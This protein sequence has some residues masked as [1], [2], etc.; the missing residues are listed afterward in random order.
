MAWVP[1]W[2]RRRLGVG[3]LS[4]RAS[5]QL[6]QPRDEFGPGVECAGGGIK[7]GLAITEAA[8]DGGDDGGDLGARELRAE[9]PGGDDGAVPV[10]AGGVGGAGRMPDTPGR[11][12]D[13]STGLP[14]LARASTLPNGVAGR[15]RGDGRSEAALG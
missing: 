5:F 4:F 6:G 13:G 2:G 14:N 15:Q 7:A 10:A 12:I 1:G 11:A 3:F 8:V 9:Q